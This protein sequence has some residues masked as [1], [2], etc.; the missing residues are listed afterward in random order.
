[1][2]GYLNVL[3]KEYNF[4]IA[5]NIIYVFNVVIHSFTNRL[6]IIS[7][8]ND[9]TITNRPTTGDNMADEGNVVVTDITS[10]MTTETRNKEPSQ[11]CI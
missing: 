10:E 6:K 8:A 5:V 7:N 4:N 1:M 9:G 2:R 11:Y 3:N